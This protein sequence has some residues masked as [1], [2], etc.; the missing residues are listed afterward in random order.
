MKK[1]ENRLRTSKNINFISLIEYF[2]LKNMLNFYD[3]FF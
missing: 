2:S 1:I 3:E